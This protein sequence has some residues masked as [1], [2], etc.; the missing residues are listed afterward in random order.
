MTAPLTA[1]PTATATLPR[2]T[3]DIWSD[4]ACPWCYVGKRRFEA[5]LSQFAQAEQVD[6]VWHSFELDPNAPIAN[7]VGMREIGRAHV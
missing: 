5:A 2:V 4:I 3:V 1:L 7:P 6:V